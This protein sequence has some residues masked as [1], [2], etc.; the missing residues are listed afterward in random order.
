MLK[1]MVTRSASHIQK[2]K[3]TLVNEETTVAMEWKELEYIFGSITYV[4]E[5]FF[6]L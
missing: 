2:R 5:I 1:Y 3:L 6:V 4:W